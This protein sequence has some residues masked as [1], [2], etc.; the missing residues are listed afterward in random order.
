MTYYVVDERLKQYSTPQ[1]WEYYLAASRAGRN[2]AAKD[3][4]VNPSTIS[5]SIKALKHKAAKFGYAPDED[6]EQIQAHPLSGTSTLYNAEGEITAQWVKTKIDKDERLDHLAELISE[7]CANLKPLPPVP[8]PKPKLT[9]DLLTL[10]TLTDYHLGMYSWEKETG[11][12]WSMKEAETVLRNAIGAMMHGSPDTDTAI[13]NL[14]GD[15]LHWDS[16]TPETP[17]GKNVVDADA[18]FSRMV[19]LS[20]TVTVDSVNKLLEKHKKV[21][22]LVCEGNHDESGSVWLRKCIKHLFAKNKRVEVDDTEFPYYAYLHGQIMLGFH[23]G[24]K[25][26][27]KLLPALFSSEPRYREMWGNA[28]YTYIHTG[29][30]HRA[31]QDMAEHGGAIV[32]RHPTLASRD[33]YAARGGWVSWRTARA[34]TYHINKGETHRVSVVPDG[35]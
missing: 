30:Y 10:Y 11:G 27:N 5:R 25:K 17:R 28:L 33:A 1:Q 2:Q 23:H 14:Q 20:I 6:L 7:T 26:T 3:L 12:H 24:H 8:T 19:E 22:V 13:F 34:I 16:L 35:T 31:E 32:E 15:F 18:R 21:I 9:K 29:H 4:D